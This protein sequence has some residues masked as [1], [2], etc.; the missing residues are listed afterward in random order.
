VF[1]CEADTLDVVGVFAGED[2]VGDIDL[3]RSDFLLSARYI[4]FRHVNPVAAKSKSHTSSTCL[5]L[6][7]AL[8]YLFL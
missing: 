1:A 8:Q 4:P 6:F 5:S 7:S 2:F 3:A